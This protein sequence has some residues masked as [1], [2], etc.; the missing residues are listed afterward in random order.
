MKTKNP[1]LRQKC[2][3]I[4]DEKN[5]W[6]LS[7]SDIENDEKFTEICNQSFS[8]EDNFRSFFI[9]KKYELFKQSKQNQKLIEN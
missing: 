8:I 1:E 9:R 6:T 7:L 2:E 4:L 3:T 5:L